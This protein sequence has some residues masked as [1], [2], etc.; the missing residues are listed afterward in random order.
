MWACLEGNIV[1]PEALRHKST[2]MKFLR[3]AKGK[4]IAVNDPIRM[5]EEIA[6][7]DCYPGGRIIFALVRRS[8]WRG[9]LDYAAMTFKIAPYVQMGERRCA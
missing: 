2:T 3:H 5:A 4:V 9:P 8:P 1:T 6:M 7:L